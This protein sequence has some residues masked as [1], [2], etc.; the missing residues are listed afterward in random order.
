MYAKGEVDTFTQVFYGGISVNLALGKN[1]WCGW[2]V[3]N[4]IEIKLLI[5]WFP[6]DG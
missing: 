5:V 2:L 4:F 1:H 3:E 6:G